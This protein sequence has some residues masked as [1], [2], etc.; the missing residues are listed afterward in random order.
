ML[1]IVRTMNEIDVGQMLRV[2]RQSNRYNGIQN[3]P[4]QSVNMQFL[5]A[6]QDFL[7]YLKFFLD[8]PHSVYALWAPGGRYMA[9]LRLEQYK[10]GILLSGL[11]TAPEA[12]RMGCAT[13]L[14]CAVLEEFPMDAAYKLY[15][16]VKRDNCISIH[17]H[18]KCGFD[19]IL[20]HAVLIDGSI[21][22]A[23]YTFCYTVK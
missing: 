20:D 4:Y 3:Y 18:R 23:Y 17:I 11:E 14:V 22:F 5:M 2:Y 13:R 6:Q 19:K 10:D 1:K 21:S 9:A 16:H 7:D 8:S 15:S 12:R